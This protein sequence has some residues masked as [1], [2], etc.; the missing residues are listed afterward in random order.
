M[1]L[2]LMVNLAKYRITETI[3][4]WPC[5]EGNSNMRINNRERHT[6]TVSNTI[7]GTEALTCVKGKAS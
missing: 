3:C 5:L 4:L 1:E 6:L 2:I 7:S